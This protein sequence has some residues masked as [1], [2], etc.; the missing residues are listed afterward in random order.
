[1]ELCWIECFTFEQME[2]FWISLRLP[3]GYWNT[4][5]NKN[6]QNSYEALRIVFDSFWAYF[7]PLLSPCTICP[8]PP[9][10]PPRLSR[11]YLNGLFLMQAH[12]K[13][14]KIPFSAQIRLSAN[15]T[16]VRF[17]SVTPANFHSGN[18]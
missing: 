6:L 3:K 17:A 11:F 4:Y 16:E 1:M 14:S 7:R 12:A 15:G 5:E 10:P 9:T 13:K 2:L 8:G 18:N